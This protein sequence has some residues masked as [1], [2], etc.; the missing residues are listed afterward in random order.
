VPAV[1]RG[2]ESAYFV[3]F[4]KICV[5]VAWLQTKS[6]PAAIV[7]RRACIVES[8]VDYILSQSVQESFFF[9]SHTFL[10]FIFREFG[11]PG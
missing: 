8:T 3:A 4:D 6:Q 11:G 7:A 1:K 10:I 9:V 5:T 2:Y